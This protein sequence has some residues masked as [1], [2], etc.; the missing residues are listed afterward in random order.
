M[1]IVG[2]EIE[3]FLDGGILVSVNHH[4]SP[5]VLFKKTTTKEENTVV[6]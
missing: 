2:F 6:D 5:M 3:Y 1:K 4:I